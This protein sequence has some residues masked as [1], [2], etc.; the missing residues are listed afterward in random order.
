MAVVS[1]Y[2]RS[3]KTPAAIYPDN[4]AAQAEGDHRLISSGPIEI[5]SGNSIA[6]KYYLGQIPSNAILDVA[7]SILHH[8]SLTDVND[9][10]IGLEVAGTVKDV[11]VLADGINL[12]SAGTK[13]IGASVPL[14]DIGKRM[15]ELL[16]LANDP[17]VMYDIVL[18]IN[19]AAGATVNVSAQIAYAR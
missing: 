7:N 18:K 2:G 10:D 17:G 3:I 9:A 4:M 13:L 5:T 15:Y 14:A 1:K 19:V 8:G 11:D 16:G 6:S 12:T